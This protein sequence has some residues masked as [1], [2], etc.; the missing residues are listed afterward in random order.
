[1]RFAIA[2][3]FGSDNL[4]DE[5]LLHSLMS[6][7]RAA[8]PTATFVVLC[9][10]PERVTALHAVDAVHMPTLRSSGSAGRQAAAQRALRECDLLLLGPGTVFQ[11]RS[12]NLPWPGTLPMF[13]RITTMARLA[14][15]PVAIAGAGVREGATGA[16]RALL[17]GLGAAC[18]AIGVRDRRSADHF[19]SSA[20]VIGDMAY[21]LPLPPAAGPAPDRFAVSMRP[22]AEHL[23]A[24]LVA[25]LTE[26]VRRLTG[27]G[28]AGDFLPMAYG[29]DAQGEDDATIYR[30][31]FQDL[32]GLL[33]N[34]LDDAAFAVEAT[35]AAGATATGPSALAGATTATA[36]PDAAGANAVSGRDAAGR[37]RFGA[38]LDEWLARLAGHRLVIGARLH[39]V[40]PAVALGVPT[41]AIAYERKVLDAFADLGLAD[42]ALGPD[43]DA[44]AMHR[45]ALAAVAAPEIF[46]AAADRVRAQG[47]IAREFV[48]AAVGGRR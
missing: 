28:W 19:G 31:S 16:G 42:Y 44:E 27:A 46:A 5:L 7:V 14:G 29:R 15:T 48:A 12:P 24:P 43:T 4:G 36:A 25:A 45:A 6:A 21:A 39:A 17:R 22:L 3:W 11:E 37:S 41:V 8:D 38:A 35:T 18:R 30:S 10:V 34:P 33:P 47:E 20:R 40:L 23:E 32:L 2:G 13:A 1:M 9:P 26:V